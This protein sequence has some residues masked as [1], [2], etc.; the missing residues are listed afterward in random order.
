[1]LSLTFGQDQYI[2]Y[3]DQWPQF[4]DAL[5]SAVFIPVSYLHIPAI[6]RDIQC[7]YFTVEDKGQVTYVVTLSSKY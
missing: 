4:Y 6:W 2:K 5:Q 7:F 1:M 3:C